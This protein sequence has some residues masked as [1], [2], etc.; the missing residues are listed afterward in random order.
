MLVP[1]VHYVEQYSDLKSHYVYIYLLFVQICRF[2]I[3]LYGKILT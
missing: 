3:N 2:L 1:D